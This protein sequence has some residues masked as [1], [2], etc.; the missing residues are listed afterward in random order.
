MQS[1]KEKEK[2]RSAAIPA[3]WE[4]NALADLV[5]VE[6]AVVRMLRHL[7]TRELARKRDHN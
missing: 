5:P 7:S 3:Q 4:R 2:K 1:D 6:R